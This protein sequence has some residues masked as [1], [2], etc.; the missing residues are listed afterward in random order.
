M[1]VY[2][3]KINSNIVELA[4][5]YLENIYKDMKEELK[6]KQKRDI[7]RKSKYISHHHIKIFNYRNHTYKISY[8]SNRKIP[9]MTLSRINY[10]GKDLKVI[11][12]N[13]VYILGSSKDLKSI[14]FTSKIVRG[15]QKK[16]THTSIADKNY[17]SVGVFT[18]KLIEKGK[19]IW[20][21]KDN[22]IIIGWRGSYS[23]PTT[24]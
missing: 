19:T 11:S 5:Q 21:D 17:I 20:L 9:I 14:E 13:L 24:R 3:R 15:T 6:Q 23:P 8:N 4:P 22:N 16:S 2:R 10:S 1:S 12:I 7:E 18:G